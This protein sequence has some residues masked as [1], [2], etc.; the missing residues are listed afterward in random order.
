MIVWVDDGDGS[1]MG[2]D[3]E[4][5]EDGQDPDDFRRLQGNYAYLGVG[6]DGKPIFFESNETLSEELHLKPT[7]EPS[8]PFRG[9]RR[10][11]MDYFADGLAE[12]GIKMAE[13]LLDIGQHPFKFGME[14]HAFAKEI[15]GNPLL[16][17]EI[18]PA[19]LEDLFSDLRGF[20]NVDSTEQAKRLGKTTG[21]LLIFLAPGGAAAKGINLG[22]YPR[23][24]KLFNEVEARGTNKDA[25]H[26]PTSDSKPQTNNILA[27]V[28]DNRVP[29]DSE[30]VLR[31]PEYR[32]TGR[33]RDHVKI[34]KKG[35]CY[36]YRDTK[37][38]GKSAHLEVFDKRGKHLGEADPQTGEIRPGTADSAK[39]LE[40]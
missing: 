15:A 7:Q 9:R 36:Y 37:H 11:H 13:E 32:F 40:L 30:T 18:P 25:S 20:N 21:K 19:M 33:T 26:L 3:C 6:K 8:I 24:L 27:Y 34:Y 1:G 2:W 35:D 31:N 23:L 5:I 22:K 29:L 28:R 17:A 10:G 12:S 14:L 38:F 16:A 4:I 39:K